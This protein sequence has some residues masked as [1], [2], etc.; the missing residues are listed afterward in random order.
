MWCKGRIERWK[1]GSLIEQGGRGSNVL[2][3]AATAGFG[4]MNVV[5]A[6]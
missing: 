5:V 3:V 1:C 2:A 6:G 4:R